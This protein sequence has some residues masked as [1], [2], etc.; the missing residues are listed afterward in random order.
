[1]CDERVMTVHGGEC[2]DA[3]CC[4]HGFRRFPSR[5]ERRE[6]LEAYRDELKNELVGV[7]ER[8]QELG[9]E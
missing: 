6:R 4:G 3:C 1:M 7:E 5:R 9:S 8:I 2:R